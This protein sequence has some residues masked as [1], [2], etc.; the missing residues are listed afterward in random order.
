[1]R[2]ATLLCTLLSVLAVG[3]GDDETP[4]MP[5]PGMV[6]S[7]NPEC[8]PCFRALVTQT[9]PCGP[10]LDQCLD[11]PTL[12]LAPIVVCFETEGQCFNDALQVSSQCNTSCGDTSQS[13]VE[14]CAGQCFVQR[15]DCAVRTVRGVDACLTVCGGDACTLC[16][17]NGRAAFADCNTGLESCV[18]QCK[19]TFRR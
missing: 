4:G 18:E 3:C 8:E 5:G 10:A 12:P 15:A 13:Q 19:T 17:D 11:D 7:T 9:D 6:G 1:M 16:T 2:T 14:S